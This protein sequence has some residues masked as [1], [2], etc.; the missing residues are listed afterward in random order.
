[1]PRKKDIKAKEPVRLRYKP[2]AN[3]NKSIYLDKY[4]D[5]NREYEFLNLYIIPEVATSDKLRN[6]ETLRTAKAIQ[7]KKIIDLQND[8]NG[9]KSTA[10]NSKIN[11]LQYIQHLANE[12]LERTGNKRSNYHNLL[13]LNRHLEAYNGTGITLKHFDEAFVMG[14]LAYLRTA[15]SFNKPNGK[16]APLISQN[17]R[18]KLF[19]KLKFVA[20]KAHKGGIISNNPFLKI[21]TADKPQSEESKREYLTVEEIKQLIKTDCKDNRLKRAF[22][23]CCLTGLRYSDVTKITWGNFHTDNKAGTELQFKQQKTKG[24]MYLQISQEAV[25]WL[26]NRNEAADT[27]IIFPL[28]KNDYANKQLAKW[29]QSAG[30][31]KK[32]TFHCSRH[33][34][35]TLNLTLGVCMEVTS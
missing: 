23:F 19:A 26:P 31:N 10:T 21:D 1:M 18:H 30:I 35:A 12:N 11:L 22:L 33:T 9:F 14:F 2:L 34:A 6:D 28:P 4:R 24:I 32:I 20:T 15:K 5:G 8:E 13:S 25:K 29:V 3:G 17:T 7:A 27:D 16:P